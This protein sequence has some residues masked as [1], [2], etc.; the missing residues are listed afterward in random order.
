MQKMHLCNSV[1]V[2]NVRRGGVQ[3]VLVYFLCCSFKVWIILRNKLALN[4][5][6]RVKTIMLVQSNHKT[7]IYMH[8]VEDYGEYT[9]WIQIV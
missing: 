3:G 8:D 4:Q 5:T 7:C 1:V 2:G 9:K 6:Q